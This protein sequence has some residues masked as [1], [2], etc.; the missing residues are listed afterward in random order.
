MRDARH[1]IRSGGVTSQGGALAKRV[2]EIDGGFNLS[3]NAYAASGTLARP[4]SPS[5][6]PPNARLGIEL[7]TEFRRRWWRCAQ[8]SRSDE[9][10]MKSAVFDEH[11]VGIVSGDDNPRDKDARLG[12]LE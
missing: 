9:V 5:S 12:R 4:R 6:Y 10:A 11:L 8:E 2:A 1:R 3:F 7:A